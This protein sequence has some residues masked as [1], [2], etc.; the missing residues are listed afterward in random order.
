MLL[1]LRDL[2]T[3]GAPETCVPNLK[4]TKFVNKF[5]FRGEGKSR[6]ERKGGSLMWLRGPIKLVSRPDFSLLGVRFRFSDEHSW[7][8]HFTRQTHL[9]NFELKKNIQEISTFCCS[10][11][12]EELVPGLSSS[13]S[14]ADILQ[15]PS[16]QECTQGR[17]LQ[18]EKKCVTK[19][20]RTVSWN[21]NMRYINLFFV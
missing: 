5:F 11:L 18:S 16:W 1:I 17:Y 2:W 15:H 13:G 9:G 4:R 20:C 19:N 7:L 6:E 10:Q 12:T 3:E 21:S 14:S 8:F